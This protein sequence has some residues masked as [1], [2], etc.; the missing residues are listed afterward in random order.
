MLNMPKTH[1]KESF[2]I[3][4]VLLYLSPDLFSIDREQIMISIE[5]TLGVELVGGLI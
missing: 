5:E 1:E 3:H 2:N 4:P